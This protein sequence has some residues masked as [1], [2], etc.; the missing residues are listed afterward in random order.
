MS[1]ADSS[2]ALVEGDYALEYVTLPGKIGAG[3][4]GSVNMCYRRSDKK[5]VSEQRLKKVFVLITITGVSS[6]L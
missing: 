2:L 3:A 1:H 4:F 5:L 6:L